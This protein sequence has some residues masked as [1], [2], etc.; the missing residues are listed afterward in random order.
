MRATEVAWLVASLASSI[1]ARAAASVRAGSSGSTHFMLISEFDMG[2]AER[3][4]EP[5][6]RLPVTA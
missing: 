3:R 2:K 5:H 1:A 6:T 4:H